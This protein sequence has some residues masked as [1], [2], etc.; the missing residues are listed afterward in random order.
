[1][2]QS[3]IE[4]DMGQIRSQDAYR[5]MKSPSRNQQAIPKRYDMHP[6]KEKH[7][8]QESESI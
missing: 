3:A 8:L 4:P 1:M 7:Y 2:V 6:N 5:L